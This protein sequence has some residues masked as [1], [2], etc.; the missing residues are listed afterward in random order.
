MEKE[1][2]LEI[3]IEEHTEQL[4]NGLRQYFR[5]V[6]MIDFVKNDLRVLFTDLLLEARNDD[7]LSE[8][9]EYGF[10]LFLKELTSKTGFSKGRETGKGVLP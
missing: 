6:G 8:K 2:P 9:S 7:V 4:V 5:G 3:D 1:Y 10:E